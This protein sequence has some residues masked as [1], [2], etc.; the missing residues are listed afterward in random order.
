[1]L[2][3]KCA[4]LVKKV[5]TMFKNR[6]II[7]KVNVCTGVGEDMNV[8]IPKGIR[9][10]KQDNDLIE[11]RASKKGWSFNQWVNRAIQQALRRR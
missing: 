7:G 2:I 8:T 9:I 6:F 11:K 5:L 4:L 1:M 3:N 10:S